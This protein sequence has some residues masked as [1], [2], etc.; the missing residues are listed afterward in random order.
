VDFI[1]LVVGWVEGMVRDITIC[2]KNSDRRNGGEELKEAGKEDG[3]KCQL[4][5][6]PEK[7][8]CQNNHE[9][10]SEVTR[11]SGHWNAWIIEGQTLKDAGKCVSSRK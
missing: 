4:A 9:E 6:P 5:Y 7:L 10:W 11:D 8:T 2:R 1:V 3:G